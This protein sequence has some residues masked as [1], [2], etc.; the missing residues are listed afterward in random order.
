MADQRR[1]LTGP[2]RLTGP[3]SSTQRSLLVSVDALC[4]RTAAE[5]KAAECSVGILTGSLASQ[6]SLERELAREGHDRASLGRDAFVERMRAH[7]ASAREEA[8]ADALALGIQLDLGAAVSEVE[9]A[10][11]AARTAFVLLYEAGLLELADRVVGTC[12]RCEAV[13]EGVDAEE[14]SHETD[15]L[16]LRV[17]LSEEGQTLEVPVDAPELL[18]GAVALV[19]PIGADEAGASAHVPLAEN[20]IPVIA[21][22]D[23]DAPRFIVPGHSEEDLAIA[24]RHGLLPVLVIDDDGA[25]QLLGPLHGQTRFAA[26]ATATERL[27]EG[28][29]IIGREQVDEP[30]RRCRRCG[31]LVVDRL[32]RHWFLRTAELEV[33]AADAVRQGEVDFAPADAREE[34][35]ER[36]GQGESW[37][38]SSRV[39]AGVP[40]PVATC[41]DCGRVA[42]EVDLGTSCNKCMGALEADDGALDARFVGVVWALATL[43]WPDDEKTYAAQAA[44]ALFV[45]TRGGL[46]SWALPM[47]ALGLR[48][49]RTVPFA[50]VAALAPVESEVSAVSSRP[51][52]RLAALSEGS[53]DDAATLVE[54]FAHPPEGEG[55]IDAILPLY[56]SAFDGGL[57]GAALDVLASLV[58]GG[59]PASAA[60]RVR[61]LAAPLLGD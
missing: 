35:L 29:Q 19:V 30:A 31:T 18:L 48:L 59:V 17:A 25:V 24:R 45:T 16:T 23:V 47:A 2:L 56:E 4:R 39:L 49:G 27:N 3:L 57:P 53:A 41:L 43:G 20:V 33:A 1:I 5:G 32:G 50:R 44:D 6:A 36:A 7:E 26:R 8:V 55:D 37:C 61:A 58:T 21:D 9:A 11:E 40:V 54:A 52:A 46:H 10:E 60:D 28:G 34:F 38:L 13:V 15:R 22:P 51:A 14:S 42:V 12:P